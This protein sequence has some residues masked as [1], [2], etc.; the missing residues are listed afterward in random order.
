MRTILLAA[1]TALA[2]L[3]ATASAQ[4]EAAAVQA[5]ACYIEIHKLM[6]EPPEG[7]GELGAAIRELDLAL[8]PQVEEINV[9]RAQIA[10]IERQAAAAPAAPASI[11]PCRKAAARSSSGCRSVPCAGDRAGLARLR[12]TLAA[13][14]RARRP[15]RRGDPAPPGRAGHQAGQA[16]ARLRRAPA[17]AGRS[18]PGADQP[19]RAGR[20]QHERGLRRSEDGADA[21]ASRADR[22]RRAQRDRRVRRLVSGESAGLN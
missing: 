9:L 18:G 15:R 22:R 8:R 3:S 10:R 4:G 7:I 14:R 6:A 11:S 19:R 2:A 17:G 21:R 12:G 16:Q 13:D 5:P 1:G 20:R